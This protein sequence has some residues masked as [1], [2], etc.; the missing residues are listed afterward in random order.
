MRLP[1]IKERSIFARWIP[2]ANM[3]LALTYTQIGDPQKDCLMRGFVE[4]APGST[5]AHANLGTLYAMLGYSDLAIGEFKKSI[6]LNAKQPE[7]Y[8]SLAEEFIKL[9]KWEQARE[10]LED[11]KEFAPSPAVSERLGL[12]YYKLGKL[13]KATLNYE[14]SLQQ[15]SQLFPGYE[16][17]G[18][19]SYDPKPAPFSRRCGPGSGSH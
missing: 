7:V 10:V 17:T 12:C 6:E 5:T 8:V 11:A 3:N 19:C 16:W 1:P 13:D 15:E 4:G 14:D 18:C 2:S 9:N